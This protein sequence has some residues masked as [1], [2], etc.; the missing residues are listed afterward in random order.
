[1]GAAHFPHKKF[2]SDDGAI[3]YSMENSE[4][5]PTTADTTR[6]RNIYSDF[7]F[8]ALHCTAGREFE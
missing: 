4:L 2:P 5:G 3:Y 7:C 8:T 6:R 1:M